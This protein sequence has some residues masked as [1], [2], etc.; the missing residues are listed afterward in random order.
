M[1]G[2]KNNYIPLVLAVILGVAAVFLLQRQINQK[3]RSVNEEKVGI[4]TVS[5]DM[6]AG[7]VLTQ[8]T[9][10]IKQVPQSAVPPRAVTE[11]QLD[12]VLNQKLV[13]ALPEGSFIQLWDIHVDGGLGELVN[14]G[15]WAISVSMNGGAICRRL[16]PNDH[17]AIVGTFDVD[18]QETED[19]KT[20]AG[21]GFHQPRKRKVTTVIL[22]DVRILAMDSDRRQGGDEFIVELPPQEAQVILA[23]QAK[24]VELS[25]ALRRQGDDSHL[26][27]VAAKLVDESTF[28]KMT[29]GVEA[30]EVPVTP[31]R[32]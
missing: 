17:I 29:E 28:V 8:N 24:G 18:V 16:R 3:E 13:R 19:D 22:P 23:A 27:R 1:A 9:C 25:P 10:T 20:A 12:M 6:E 2:S 26:N 7:A 31:A 14:K 5:R 21:K 32:Q 11:A 4:V 30:V 15:S